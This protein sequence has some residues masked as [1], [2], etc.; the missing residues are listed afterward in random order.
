MPINQI[1]GSDFCMAPKFTNQGF[2]LLFT[3][4]LAFCNVFL[5]LAFIASSRKC[6]CFMSLFI[7]RKKTQDSSYTNWN[8]DKLQF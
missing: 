6:A 3:F 2:P 5:Y 4:I 7:F 8:R 1:F